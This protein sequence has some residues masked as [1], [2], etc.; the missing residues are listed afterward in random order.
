[1][2]DALKKELEELENTENQENQTTDTTE[3]EETEDAVQQ[4]GQ[5]EDA[6]EEESTEAEEEVSEEEKARLAKQEAYRQR[7]KEKQEE[8]RRRKEELERKSASDDDLDEDEED[9]LA[10]IKKDL[11]QFKQIAYQQQYQQAV[12]QAERELETLEKD[13]KE[14]FNDYDD[15][16][17]QALDLTKA[18]LVGQGMSESEA[19]DYLRREKVMI[20]DRAAAAGKDP[21]EAVYNEAK[22]IVSWLDEYV[23]SQGYVKQ[24]GG[25]K[26]TNLQKMRELSKP[27]AMNG[28]RGAAAA[29]REFDDLGDDDLD[30]IKNTTIWD[31][32]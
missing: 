32:A 26:K 21:V 19:D 25:K 18:R 1:M 31:V 4:E 8:V 3:E 7:Q 6:N 17:K 24:D 11:Q 20:A 10:Q 12:K 27:N 13:F 16:V 15:V 30:E 2:T 9:E 28:G 5:D 14:A 22:G 29:K 23:Q